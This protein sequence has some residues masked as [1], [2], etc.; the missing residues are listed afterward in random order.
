MH[1]LTSTIPLVQ[2]FLGTAWAIVDGIDPRDAYEEM[3]HISEQFF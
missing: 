3:E 1:F 2:L